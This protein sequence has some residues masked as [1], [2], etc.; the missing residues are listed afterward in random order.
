MWT[1]LYILGGL[2]VGGFAGAGVAHFLCSRR[3]DRLRESQQ[4]LRDAHVELRETLGRR[5][6]ELEAARGELEET[7]AE[8]A[9]ARTALEE[10]RTANGELREAQARLQSELGSER[11]AAAEKLA[12]WEEAE[13]RFRETFQALSSKALKDN[14]QSFLE[15]AR[16]HLGEYQ[17]SATQELEGRQKAIGELVKPIRESLQKVDTRLE[18]VEAARREAYG[19]LTEQVKTMAAGQERLHNETQRLVQALHQPHVRGNWGEVQLRRVVEMAGMEPYCDFQEQ[20]AT[21]DGTLRPDLIVRLPGGKSVVVDAKTPL[22]AYLK[23]MEVGGEAACSAYLEEHARQVKAHLRAL[24]GK[25]YWSQFEDTPEFV[26]M[27][28]PGET[29]FSAALKEDPTLIEYGVKQRV[30]L[31]SPTTLIALLQAVAYGWKQERLAENARAISDLGRELYDRIRTLTENFLRVGKHL[32]QGVEAYNRAVGSL[33]SRVLPA[34]RKFKDLD[35]GTEK[36]IPE[37]TPV[38]RTAR[39]VQSDELLAPPEP[40]AEPDDILEENGDEPL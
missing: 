40:P 37:A 23:A 2:L 30:V 6:V 26:V 17:K 9:A 1:A 11:K 19:V 12:A 36:E 25:A 22:E 38:D 35:A 3:E 21:G 33:E 7:D 34:A 8:L 5:E 39:S 18:S 4:T 31:A 29:F 15:L 32:D 16:T 20:P 24:G 14:S 27:F 13:K 10:A 28:L